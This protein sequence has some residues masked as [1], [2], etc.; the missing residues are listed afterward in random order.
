ME[1][2]THLICMEIITCLPHNKMFAQITHTNFK[3]Y[4]VGIPLYA[5]VDFTFKS[6]SEWDNQNLAFDKQECF[7][8]NK[9]HDS[10]Y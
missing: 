3:K 8:K 5:R 9:Q 7:W 10:G 1:L 6:P 4:S 2:V